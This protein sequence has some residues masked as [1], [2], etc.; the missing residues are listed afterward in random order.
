[1]NT[2]FLS[3]KLYVVLLA[4][5]A[6]LSMLVSCFFAVRAKS[7]AADDRGLPFYVDGGGNFKFQASKEPFAGDV[8]EISFEYKITNGEI[9]RFMIGSWDAYYGYFI[10]DKNGGCNR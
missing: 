8:E 3:K 10:L 9:I 7:Y 1:M 4:S 2:T 6:V 5:T